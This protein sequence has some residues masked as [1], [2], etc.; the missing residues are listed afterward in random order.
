MKISSK[1][2][3]LTRRSFRR[4]LI[5]FGA[6]IFASLAVTATGFAAWVLSQ[7]AVAET[8][9]GVEVGSVS[10]VGVEIKDLE[11]LKDG[12][13]PIN[14]F[15]FEPA[16]DDN[17]GRVRWDSK[18]QTPK[19]EDLDLNLS[20]TVTNYQNVT[21]S[22]IEFKVPANIQAAIDNGY[23]STPVGFTPV[24]KSETETNVQKTEVI[25]GATYYI[26]QY[27]FSPITTTGHDDV[28]D[29]TVK[30]ENGG[31]NIDFDFIL[32]F[33]WGKEFSADGTEGSIG[34]NPSVYYDSPYA[35]TTRGDGVDIEVVKE[36]LIRLK[37]TIF[38]V[39]DADADAA[40][41]K[42]ADS[43]IATGLTDIIDIL[44]LMTA[45]EQ[46]AFYETKS[47]PTYYFVVHAKV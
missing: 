13:T 27:T 37:A 18:A 38:G 22:F 28:A 17:D 4:K 8:E 35:D 9:G 16:K 33:N 12:T 42:M 5:M 14:N 47:A 19:Y 25:E 45:E 2:K 46:D 41:S 29:W 36:T 7:D 11:F 39:T 20:W 26:Y 44:A 32:K 30:D 43:S 23:I 34:Q 1:T 24:P 10:D 3:R 15:V 31:K 40:R 21:S 6:S